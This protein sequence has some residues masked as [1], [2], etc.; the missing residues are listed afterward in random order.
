MKEKTI[1]SFNEFSN[2]IEEISNQYSIKDFIKDFKT[3]LIR[4]KI[5]FWKVLGTNKGFVNPVNEILRAKN[6]LTP[7]EM[8]KVVQVIDMLKEKYDYQ[9]FL[10]KC[11]LI[12]S[13]FL[14]ERSDYFSLQMTNFRGN[15]RDEFV[16]EDMLGIQDNVLCGWLDSFLGRIKPDSLKIEYEDLNG[17][18]K[19]SRIAFKNVEITRD[20]VECPLVDRYTGS[21][22]FDSFLLRSF[23]DVDMKHWIYIPIRFIISV[24]NASTSKTTPTENT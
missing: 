21:T 12:R 5:D 14:S 16:M 6:E 1:K 24:D 23:Y 22:Q 10:K 20:Y 3:K 2:I 8:K 17:D 15:A 9:E 18:I 19:S 7:V 4:R 11:D 13:K